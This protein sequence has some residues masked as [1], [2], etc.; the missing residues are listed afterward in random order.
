[1]PL[2]PPCLVQRA[3]K[4]VKNLLSDP[5]GISRLHTPAWRSTFIEG[6]WECIQTKLS[7]ASSQNVYGGHL[8]AMRRYVLIESRRRRGSHCPQLS[9]LRQDKQLPQARAH[10]RSCSPSHSSKVTELSNKSEKHFDQLE[11]TIEHKADCKRM[12]S[13]A[14][15]KVIHFSPG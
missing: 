10:C 6:S 7:T 11:H 2:G 14:A 12:P 13:K 3:G 5:F 1:M 9:R 8:E 4:H 15:S